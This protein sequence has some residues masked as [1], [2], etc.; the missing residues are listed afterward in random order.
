MVL[1][2]NTA[3]FTWL[4]GGLMPLPTCFALLNYLKWFENTFPPPGPGFSF[5]DS[6]KLVKMPTTPG[7]VQDFPA[8]GE[9]LWALWWRA[10]SPAVCIQFKYS[11]HLSVKIHLWCPWALS[12]LIIEGSTFPSPPQSLLVFK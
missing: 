1:T 10:S 4:N 2:P 11:A 6:P 12:S 8:Q 5:E 9:Q 3:E 7:T